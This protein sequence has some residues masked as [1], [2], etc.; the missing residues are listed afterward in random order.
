[1]ISL[2][3]MAG[4]IGWLAEN[5]YTFLS[6]VGIIAGLV[7][8]AAS[9]RADTRSRRL[10]NLVKLTEQHRDIWEELQRKPHLGRIKESNV[11]LYT[12][13]V[14]VEEAQFVTLLI[15]HLHCW[16]RAILE[17]E[18]RS[19]EGLARDVQSFFN[20]PIAAYVWE[21]H[22]AFHDQDFV[23]FVERLINPA[24]H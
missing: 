5:G 22:R 11:D 18:V 24:S 23:E 2:G 20:R 17:G 19:P 1:M 14:T 9:F 6:A 8:T 16:Y 4:T 12:K 3:D 21:K 10:S 13:P 7:F 15:L